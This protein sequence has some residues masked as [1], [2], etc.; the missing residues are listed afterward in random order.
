MAWQVAG[1]KGWPEVWILGVVASQGWL[2]FVLPRYSHFSTTAFL[3]IPRTFF[4]T[5][6]LEI[7]FH[8]AFHM[9]P[10][11][12]NELV[13]IGIINTLFTDG[14]TE[15]WRQKVMLPESSSCSK[16][17]AGKDTGL[18]ARILPTAFCCL[19]AMRNLGNLI[20]M[21]LRIPSQGLL[22]KHP[23]G[24]STNLVLHQTEN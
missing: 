2:E 4:I 18:G 24:S 5:Y 14:L 10:E 8:Q 15:T 19:H 16:A 13:R 6:S 12:P 22:I 9:I 7:S 21:W 17:R 11:Q 1:G 3:M 23:L 20:E